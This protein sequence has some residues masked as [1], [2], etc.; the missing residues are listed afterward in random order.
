MRARFFCTPV[1]LE[2]ARGRAL[3]KRGAF[4]ASRRGRRQATEAGAYLLRKFADVP[5]PLPR[6]VYEPVSPGDAGSFLVDA[7]TDDKLRWNSSCFDWLPAHLRTFSPQPRLALHIFRWKNVVD[8]NLSPQGLWVRVPPPLPLAF[9]GPY[10]PG[11]RA[12]FFCTP[13]GLEPARGRALSKRGAFSSRRGGRQA[14]EAGAYLLRKFADVPPPL[15][16]IVYEPVS[17]GD[18]GSFLVDADTDDKLRWN[19]S[20]FDWLPAHLRTFSPQLRLALP[21]FSMEKRG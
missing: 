7:D 10:L 4:V 3:S 2:P 21:H 16:R 9:T 15:P 17:P 13:V 1:G 12:R 8:L 20:C 14:T 18:A 6:I 5:P 19:S 11:M